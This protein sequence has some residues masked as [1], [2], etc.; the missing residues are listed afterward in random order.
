M[1]NSSQ[2]TI[3]VEGGFI[4]YDDDHEPLSIKISLITSLSYNSSEKKACFTGSNSMDNSF[5]CTLQQ[6]KDM[7]D[8]MVKSKK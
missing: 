3:T 4:N 1:S 7:R 5:P 2:P 6:F 8:A